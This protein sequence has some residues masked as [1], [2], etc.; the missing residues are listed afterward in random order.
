MSVASPILPIVISSEIGL[1]KPAVTAFFILLTLSAITAT[2]SSG[3]LSDGIIAR[4]KLVGVGGV[5]GALGYLGIG[6]ATQPAHAFT[7]VLPMVGITVLFP[8]LFAAARSGIVG[9]WEREAQVMGIT[10][11]RTLFSIGFIFGTTL[12][13]WLA[14][15]TN[16]QAIFFLVAGGVLALTLFAVTVLYRVETS[17]AQR[18]VQTSSNSAPAIPILALVIP[19]AALIVLQSAD[20]T[21]NV[22]LPL[23]IFQM[24][25]DVSIAPVMFGISAAFELITLA[26]LGYLSTR[27]EERVVIAIAALVGALYFAA[28]S[29]TQA[30][31]ALVLLQVGYA[32]FVAAMVGI[33]MAYIQGLLAARAGL[34]GSLYMVVANLGSLVGIL[35]PL[36]VAGYDQKIF[37]IPATFCVTGAALLLATRPRVSAIT[38]LMR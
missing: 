13:S 10:A 24:F 15:T 31:P 4:Y 23:V 19:M 38:H 25:G 18:D 2:L 36:L 14:R 28:M 1:D 12:S 26:L 5:L 11:L 33:A 9:A 7:A 8:Q 29:F 3:Y 20:S 32:V 6:T 17:I 16:L 34:G 27:M 22:Y 30:L 35:A 21:R 37:L